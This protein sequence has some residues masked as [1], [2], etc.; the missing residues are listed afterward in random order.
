MSELPD[1]TVYIEAL[2]ARIAGAALENV[3]IRRPFLTRTVSP[4]PSE[5]IG[6]RVSS[7]SRIEKRIAIGFDND[8][9]L[10]IHLMIAGRLQRKEPGA[11]I[12]SKT[13]LAAFDFADG[14]LSL[15]EA[16]S[17]KHAAL[18][19]VSGESGLAALDPAGIDIMACSAETFREALTARNHTIKR[20]LTDP[21]I[22]S[23][24]G[25]ACSDEILHRARMS[26]IVQTQKM[27]EEETG[28]LFLAT[29]ETLSDWT[30]RLRVDASGG[31]P[32]KVT[33][34]RKGMAVHGRHKEPCPDCGAPIQRIRYADNETNYCAACQTG[35]KLL[36][37]RSLSRLLKSD[38]PRTLEE[39]ENITAEKGTA[40]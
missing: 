21:R 24:I 9:W 33:A 13:D 22:F 11:R 7:L 5:A 40:A 23:G 14:T 30:E 2:D 28:R 20:S 4:R 15:T 8:V 35:G 27:T 34:F 38:W 19:V 3:R 1:V 16:G 26:P 32:E 37:D 29:R 12:A 17:K 31:F 36:A 18:H 39:L 6:R 25:N 10:V